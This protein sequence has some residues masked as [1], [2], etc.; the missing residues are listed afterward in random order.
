MF[1]CFRKRQ[2]PSCRFLFG[3]ASVKSDIAARQQIQQTLQNH[4]ADG[5]VF[6]DGVCGFCNFFINWLIVH[7]HHRHLRYSPLQG[8][9]AQQLLPPHLWQKLSTVVL[10]TPRR[11]WVR[12]G[13]VCRI[14]MMLGGPWRIAGGLL[15]LIPS[16]LRDLGYVLIG[17]VRYR[18]FGKLAQCR[19]P[20]AEE[21]SLFLN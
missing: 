4:G 19:M 12:S 17:K 13:A 14:L 11:S 16:P 7:D 9:T 10:L 15:W 5:V 18:L 2:D 20:T 21:R 6:F 3:T 8:Q 1:D